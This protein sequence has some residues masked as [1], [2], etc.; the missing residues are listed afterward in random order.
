[1]LN[2][3]DS[4]CLLSDLSITTKS[5]GRTDHVIKVKYSPDNL[6]HA[7]RVASMKKQEDTKYLYQIYILKSAHEQLGLVA[8][9]YNRSDLDSLKSSRTGSSNI[10]PNPL[11]F[12]PDVREAICAWSYRVVDHYNL[13][14]ELVS[15]SL[16]YFDRLHARHSHQ[17][18]TTQ[19]SWCVGMASLSLTMKLHS[20]KC[21]EVKTLIKLS[22]NQFN[23]R[24][25]SEM[26]MTIMRSLEWYLHPP[27]ATEFA[28]SLLSCLPSDQVTP[29]L[30]TE[31]FEWSKFLAEIAV[32]DCF[33]VPYR[34]STVGLAAVLNVM[35]DMKLV[36][37]RC[38][39][40]FEDY[41]SDVAWSLLNT[42]LDD[43]E[44]VEVRAKLRSMADA[45]PSYTPPAAIGFFERAIRQDHERFDILHIPHEH[46]QDHVADYQHQQS[47]RFNIVSNNE[48]PKS[49]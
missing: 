32:Y 48:S 18:S 11:T 23:E 36:N 47:Q 49:S 35:Q 25:L 3:S 1:M 16:A 26:E 24:I 41:F 33:F 39:S 15:V 43:P 22:R 9:N 7:Y 4:P 8:Q 27:T 20:P 31:M 37:Q 46:N 38:Q 6:E 42:S 30:R 19:F 14:R 17:E 5:E 21:L 29:S 13:P 44:V 45:T 12:D 40:L 34:S 28:F 2:K 10:R